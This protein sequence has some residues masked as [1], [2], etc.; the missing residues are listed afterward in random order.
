[1]KN[2]N[3]LLL[4]AFLIH[5]CTGTGTKPEYDVDPNNREIVAEE[6][7]Q[8]SSY[9]YIHANEKGKQYWLAVTST[10]TEKGKTYYFSQWME[11]TDFHSKEL[12][13]D[14]DQ[15]LF[16]GDLATYPIPA[17]SAMTTQPIPQQAKTPNT[18]QDVHV[19]AVEG[20]VRL[21]ELL[22]DPNKFSGE[23]VKI[24]GQVTK[25]NSGIM[26][27]NWVHIQDGTSFGEAFDLTITTNEMLTV[28][29]VAVFEG[30]ITLNKDLGSGYFFNVLMED[31]KVS[32]QKVY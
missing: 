13:R 19:E 3:I 14:F 10:P 9:T 17:K 11:M 12:N 23:K 28:G 32:N 16:V 30:L 22:E 5:S 4:F 1:M 21:Q 18:K 15:I 2:L 20:G 24:R 25:F 29:D 27:K 7:L 6:V 26:G 31:A 8:T